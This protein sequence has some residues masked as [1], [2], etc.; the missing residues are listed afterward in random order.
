MRN[1]A[2]RAA[3]AIRRA[4]LNDGN[5]PDGVIIC[6]KRIISAAAH[7]SALA[8]RCAAEC[9]CRAQLLARPARSRCILHQIRIAAAGEIGKRRRGDHV[10][11]ECRTPVGREIAD[12]RC[13]DQRQRMTLAEKRIDMKAGV[14]EEN[15]AV[16]DGLAISVLQKSREK[17][18]P[19][20]VAPSSILPT[21]NER[22]R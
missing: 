13:A 12:D 21:A 5:E 22:S 3:C 20:M 16:G 9:S 15:R 8:A 14:A 11:A 6:A 17:T 18:L 2:A 4:N 1:Q 19:T 7:G 10:T